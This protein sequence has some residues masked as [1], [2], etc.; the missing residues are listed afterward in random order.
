MKKIIT[1]IS[2]FALA[3]L[4]AGTV[5]AYADTIVG[6]V[7][8][9][10]GWTRDMPDVSGNFAYE[11]HRAGSSGNWFTWDWD[12]TNNCAQP[13]AKGVLLYNATG[14]KGTNEMFVHCKKV[15]DRYRF[16]CD[17]ACT[18]ECIGYGYTTSWADF[19]IGWH[20]V[21]DTRNLSNPV[22]SH[23]RNLLELA[24]YRTYLDSPQ[25][26]PSFFYMVTNAIKHFDPTM[27]TK[28]GEDP[29]MTLRVIM[30]DT[31]I[32]TKDEWGQNHTPTFEGH[33]V[34]VTNYT[35]NFVHLTNGGLYTPNRVIVSRSDT[36]FNGSD[37]DNAIISIEPEYENGPDD[38]RTYYINYS[39]GD[40]AGKFIIDNY[41][42]NN[43]DVAVKVNHN[44][45]FI[46]IHTII[47]NKKSDNTGVGVKLAAGENGLN[48]HNAAIELGSDQLNGGVGVGT[49]KI[50]DQNIGIDAYAGVIRLK[51][52][53][54]GN[55]VDIT[56]NTV[57]ASIA[58]GVKLGKWAYDVSSFTGNDVKITLKNL[59]EWSAGDIVFASGRT[60]VVDPH[61]APP[62]RNGN[63]YLAALTS[64]EKTHLFYSPET[65]LGKTY[66]I[67]FDQTG[68]PDNDDYEFPVF[69]LDVKSIYNTRTKMWYSTLYD[70]LSDTGTAINGENKAIAD[71]DVLVYFGNVLEPKSVII[72]NNITI[73]SASQQNPADVTV[74]NSDSKTISSDGYTST[75]DGPASSFIT[76]A[77]GK[78]VTIGS[79]NSTGTDASGMFTIDMNNKGR[80]LDIYGTVNALG[81]QG[82]S[83]QVAG[84]RILDGYYSGN[85]G[86]VMIESTGTLNLTNV[87]ISGNNASGNGAGIYQGGTLNVSGAPT[88]G[89][90]DIVYLPTS[91]VITKAGALA[92]TVNI[93]VRLANEASGR[94]ILVSKN[95]A[96]SS[97]DGQVEASDGNKLSVTLEDLL[98]AVVYNATGLDG[99]TYTPTDVIELFLGNGKILIIKDGLKT[100]DSAVFTV[101]AAGGANPSYTVVLTGI[102]DSGSQVQQAILEVPVNTYTVT[103]SGWSWAYQNV[104]GTSASI[105]KSIAESQAAGVYSEF[106]FSNETKSGTTE[107][108]ESSKNNDFSAPNGSLTGGL[109]SYNGHAL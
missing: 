68:T 40:E 106:R 39:T 6:D 89:N 90:N 98:F 22:G 58:H 12:Y 66:D 21:V 19:P 31:Y 17:E 72:N 95:G 70:A 92:S 41:T 5:P 91:K 76:V 43:S 2:V 45:L 59:D 60:R 13:N 100:G 10:T 28:V 55:A 99:G 104:S 78:T 108:A 42:S 7:I 48:Y 51:I 63:E 35:T 79:N 57:A 71:N 27:F 64:S 105:T 46:D 77:S 16:Y 85:G 61:G 87:E 37:S 50:Q 102:D 15:G 29:G 103:E 80:A 67:Y 82:T 33:L 34:G 11:G 53:T 97:L 83:G 44:A 14:N 1:R 9:R 88:F 23:G 86:A 26:L 4:C 75:Y 65:D 56:D 109:S 93:P 52:S 96:S 25:D 74:A 24:H 94:D 32:V 47:R 81:A 36:D 84:L 69:R 8:V 54:P 49:C 38:E 101:T 62:I 30:H 18:V 73:R 107:H 20:P 3:M